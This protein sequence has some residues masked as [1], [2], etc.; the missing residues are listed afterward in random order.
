MLGRIGARG[1]QD[2][3]AAGQDA[4]HAGKIERL[5]LVL[6]HAA[7]AFQ[8]ADKFVFVMENALADHR[9]NNSV[10]PRAVTA[11][12]KNSDLHLQL[13]S[14]HGLAQAGGE[15]ALAMLAARPTTW[16]WREE[17]RLP[18][19]RAQTAAAAGIVKMKG[20]VAAEEWRHAGLD[21]CSAARTDVDR[22][23]PAGESVEAIKLCGWLAGRS[24]RLIRISRCLTGL[25]Q[26]LARF[27][28]E[29]VVGVGVQAFEDHAMRR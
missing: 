4:A 9:T 19:L 26:L 3:A 13:P 14:T 10:K 5:G 20:C 29:V 6:L 16:P 11:T 8:E 2:G 7:P 25:G 22:L 1:A 12:G 18:R 21:F 27:N 15:P 17:T 24:R 28:G 23:L